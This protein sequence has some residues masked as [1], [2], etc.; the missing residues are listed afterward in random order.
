VRFL[1]LTGPAASQPLK[2]HAAEARQFR[3]RAWAAFLLVLLAL[4]L[5][6]LRYVFLQVV[7]HEEFAT[8]SANNQVRLVPVPPNRGLIYDRRGRPIA[9]N[10]PAY[11]LELVPEKVGGLRE[12]I[13]SL[14]KIV[15]LPEDAYESFEAERKRY[16]EFDSVPLK[17]N[18]SD[19]EVA[20]LAVDRHRYEGVEVVPY[21]ARR[22]PYGELLTHVL[23]YVGRLDAEDLARVDAGNY[24]GTSHIGKT[25]IERFYETRLH[26]TSGMERLETNVQGRTLQVLGRDAPVHGE[27]LVLSLD[28]QL[29][30]V[31]WEALGDRAGAV[32]AIDPNDGSV[33]ALVSKPAFDPNL[34]VGGIS[35]DDYR[36][37][38]EAPGRPL[39]NR[40]L[41]GGYEPGSTIKPFLGLAGLELG[42]I[43]TADRAYSSGRFFLPGVD[44]P[45]RDWKK[46]GH[47][48]VDIYGALE[49]SVNTYFYELALE[50]GID[51]MHDYLAQFGFGSPSGLDLLGENAGVLPSRAW[52][53]G[54]LGQ[55]WYPG[56]TVIA[57]IGQG[58]NVVT[59]TQ[60]ANAVATLA[61]G[62]TRFE[63]RLLYAGKRPGDSHA[64][65]AQAPVALQLPVRNPANWDVIREGMRRVVHGPQGTARAIRPE[66]PLEIAGKSGTAQVAAQ[67]ED[68]DM[69]DTTAAHLRHHALFIAFAP[70]AEPSIAVAAVVE[71]GGGGSRQ[72]APVAR[73]VIDAW[74]EHAQ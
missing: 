33:L 59:P 69:D 3:A 21:L 74:L 47:G 5:L 56:E 58:F 29:Q 73:A 65:R 2:D 16:R 23:G 12:T 60:L 68:E 71:H 70:V 20:R 49:Q 63:P 27:D 38:L 50:L 43:G 31:A 7:S 14:G 44:K 40:A 39:F 53:R 17:F 30:Q 25:G 62:G 22:Y 28:V 42:V 18:L 64:R 55:P 41:L 26:G 45:F 4:L 66:P 46:G 6:G 15:E 37:I 19:E 54:Q 8:R 13:D 32:V 61:N 67:A 9:E 34:F 35:R 48:W 36:S 10:Q 11:R 57:G 52:K 24:R 51:R 1:S 72:A